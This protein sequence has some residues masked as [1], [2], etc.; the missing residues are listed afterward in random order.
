MVARPEEVE[1]ALPAVEREHQPNVGK[2]TVL[3]DPPE[4]RRGALVD[5]DLVGIEVPQKPPKLSGNRCHGAIVA[6]RA[7]GGGRPR[8][9]CRVA[10]LTSDA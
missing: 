9:A 8:A 5:V 2:A 1:D 3:E 7:A 4:D 6:R 10:P